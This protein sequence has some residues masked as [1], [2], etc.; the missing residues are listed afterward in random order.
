M[1]RRVL[2]VV[3]ILSLLAASAYGQN[4]LV[5]R[6]IGTQDV[7]WAV[8]GSGAVENFTYTTPDGK[9]LTLNKIDATFLKFRRALYGLSY[10]VEDLFTGEITVWDATT[11]ASKITAL[12]SNQA[13]IRTGT[14]TISIASSL[15]VPANITLKPIKGSVLNVAS[16]TPVA[17]LTIQ[18]PIEAGPYQ[19]FS[20]TGA[21]VVDVS[22]S[23]T[24]DLYWQWYG[25]STSASDNYAAL[26]MAQTHMDLGRQNMHITQGIWNIATPVVLP[27]GCRIK[28][29]GLTVTSFKF[30]T[31]GQ[32]SMTIGDNTGTL[33]YPPV[34]KGITFGGGASCC[35]YGLK[36]WQAHNTKLEDVNFY[37]GATQ[38]AFWNDGS[39]E[40]E[41][42]RLYACSFGGAAMIGSGGFTLPQNCFL[43]TGT[44]PS[45]NGYESNIVKGYFIIEGNG[46]ADHTNGVGI[47]VDGSAD[48]STRGYFYD[49]SGVLE[50]C[51]YPLI[52][53]TAFN[54]NIHDLDCGDYCKNG[55]I[56]R[57]SG[58]VKLTNVGSQGVYFGTSN[59][60]QALISNSTNVSIDC[61]SIGNLTIDSNCRGTVIGTLE[62]PVFVDQAPDT[63]V[64]GSIVSSLSLPQIAHGG[65]APVKRNLLSNSLFT[66]WTATAPDG[67]GPSPGSPTITKAGTGIGG[68]TIN[69]ASDFSMKVVNATGAGQ[70]IGTNL[71]AA[72]LKA[73]LGKVVNFSVW[74]QLAGGQ[75]FG[76]NYPTALVSY[77]LPARVNGATYQVGQAVTIGTDGYGYD[78]L[79]TVGGVA[80]AGAPTFPTPPFYL[81][82]MITDGAVTWKAVA[83]AGTEFYGSYQQFNSADVGSGNW[84]QIFT[85]GYIPSN[86]TG[87]SAS[88]YQVTAASNATSTAHWAEPALMIG[89]QGPDSLVPGPGEFPNIIYVNGLGIVADAYPPDNSSSK[90]YTGTYFKIG[91]RCFNNGA[92][93]ALTTG[94]A[95]V[96]GCTTAGTPGSWSI[97]DKVH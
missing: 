90:Y 61:S 46:P 67:W 51:P 47:K 81:G 95:S 37:L 1:K 73:V 54:A 9:V 66:R 64:I 8:G 43:I 87:V 29:D 5:K 28:G 58:N 36:L 25:A 75:A 17:T 85:G 6:L 38:Y 34:I 77:T 70:F 96:W 40:V 41:F 2:W 92:V 52:F 19:I 45:E 26:M 3:L 74:G 76:T 53:D 27:H 84:K 18:G 39:I 82:T 48:F 49:I 68:D 80:G 83:Y 65:G 21:G 97:I 20:W 59:P 16:T 79:C 62:C 91:D 30:D 94:N 14:G 50:N 24:T 44:L 63:K 10:S 13:T 7:N 88:I 89:W 56:I 72:D 35:T 71:S 78:W 15:T 42:P 11:L 55:P 69:H 33:F 93:T 31:P 60:V 57:N 23:P 12:G 4:V 86:A 22:G 32:I